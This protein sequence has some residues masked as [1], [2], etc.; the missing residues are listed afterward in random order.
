MLELGNYGLH[1]PGMLVYFIPSFVAV[2][3]NHDKRFPIFALNLV[4]G[5]TVIGWMGALVWSLMRQV[6]GLERNSAAPS[7]LS[8]LQNLKS[9][10]AVHAKGRAMLEYPVHRHQ[11]KDRTIQLYANKREDDQWTCS[12]LVS[13]KFR[14]TPWVEN[15]AYPN[16]P[17]ASRHEAEAAGLNQAQQII[18]SIVPHPCPATT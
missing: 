16:G 17:F 3:R 5:W 11:Y 10:L 8:T 1:G 18:D 13:E 12:Y 15:T 9:Y 7:R 4:L 6:K 2:A 14:Q